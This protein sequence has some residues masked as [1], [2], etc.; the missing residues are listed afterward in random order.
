ML[1]RAGN[2]TGISESDQATG[3]SV[4]V[5]SGHSAHGSSGWI[6]LATAVA[7]HQADSGGVSIATGEAP[8]GRSGGVNIVSGSGRAA[9]NLTFQSGSATQADGGTVLLKAGHAA[10]EHARGG[11]VI[12][13]GGNS[14]AA[15]GGTV[16]CVYMMPCALLLVS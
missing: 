16:A 7:G 8:E 13:S 2:V 11:G 1:I 9:G 3:G 6:R 14:K 4:A 15:Q 10:A 12:L 5:H